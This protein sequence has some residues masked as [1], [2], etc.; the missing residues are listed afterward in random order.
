VCTA[1]CWGEAG[2][3]DWSKPAGTGAS[4]LLKQH[5]AHFTV[6]GLVGWAGPLLS[7]RQHVLNSCR[8]GHTCENTL[9]P[10]TVAR[11]AAACTSEVC[12]QHRY[13][14]CARPPVR[15]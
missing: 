5:A 7:G 9:L 14:L 6:W 3:E 11:V 12:L 15:I 10:A 2:I 4:R 8:L 13:N 1:A